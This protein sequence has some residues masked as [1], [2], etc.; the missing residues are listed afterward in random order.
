MCYKQVYINRDYC[1]LCNYNIYLFV[2]AYK[3]FYYTITKLRYY[4]SESI[5]NIFDNILKLRY[6]INHSFYNSNN[7]SIIYKMYNNIINSLELIENKNKNK[8][9][10]INSNT[11]TFLFIIYK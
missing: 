1:D 7:F 6:I 10:L 8:Y 11:Q 5:K 2:T 9:N 4:P 3:K